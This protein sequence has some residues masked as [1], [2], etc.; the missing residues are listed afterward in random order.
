MPVSPIR[1]LLAISVLAA[2]ACSTTPPPPATSQA[3]AAGCA[4][5]SVVIA[6]DFEGASQSRC[7]AD[8]ERAFT[9]VVSPEHAPPINPS[10]WYAFRYVAAPGGPDSPDDGVS[11]T[12]RYEGAEHRYP[13]EWRAGSELRMPEVSLSPDGLE[14]SFVVTAGSATVS[15]QELFGV[16]RH[17]ALLARL[18]AREGNTRLT[19]GYSR[20]GRPIEA[21]TMGSPNAP[22]LVIL[23]GRAHPPEVSGAVAMEGFLLQLADAMAD[24][25]L[26]G[27][28]FQILAVP[29]LNPDGVV[30]GHWRANTGG[31]D[32]NR[33]W[34]SFTQPETRAV[35]QWLDA[36]PANVAP[37]VMLDFHS[38]RQNLFYV[39]GDGET[40]AVQERFLS[41]WLAGQEQ[42]ITGY[43]F[44]IER[45]NA[46]PGSGTSKNWFFAQYNIP[47]YTYEVGD[48]TDRDAAMLAA[49]EL[50]QR[51]VAATEGL[52]QD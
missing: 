50:A 34:G 2:G 14:A 26:D 35:K 1:I 22:H 45:R 3:Q 5:S 19:L 52:T 46:N 40:N 9:I 44:T 37:L 41:Q 12:L 39:Q 48:E 49:Q 20:E 38:T 43:P 24:G 30:R 51:F 18:A 17:A 10:P 6:F 4:S 27:A 42:A 21:L 28:R 11:I 15:A 8:G 32:L 16:D 36:L 25:R 47:A 33:D 29:L 23:L 7:S 31:I 13:P